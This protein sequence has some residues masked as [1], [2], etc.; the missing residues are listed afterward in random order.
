MCLTEIK[1]EYSLHFSQLRYL[2]AAEIIRTPEVS[3]T[4]KNSI[5]NKK[6]QLNSGSSGT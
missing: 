2:N 4:F 6:Y 5:T 1:S 3:F